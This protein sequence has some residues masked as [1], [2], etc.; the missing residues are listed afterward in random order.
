MLSP[1]TVSIRGARVKIT[2]HYDYGRTFINGD[3]FAKTYGGRML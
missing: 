1:T 3:G 2:L